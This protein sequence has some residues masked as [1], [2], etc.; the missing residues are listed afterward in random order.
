[1]KGLL[2]FFRPA[3]MVGVLLFVL[4]NVAGADDGFQAPEIA[5]GNYWGAIGVS[6]LA[7]IGIGI[8]AFK[9]PHRTHLD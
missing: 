3:V 6:V 8:V 7:A 1:M 2:R 9:N 4:A 5:K